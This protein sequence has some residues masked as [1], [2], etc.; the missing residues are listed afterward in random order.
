MNTL[1]LWA[2]CL[3]LTLGAPVYA[4]QDDH[5]ANE[6]AGGHGD[7]EEHGDHDEEGGEEGEGGATE[8]TVAQQRVA[9]IVIEALQPQSL[10]AEIGAPGEVTLNAYLTRK[11]TPRITAQ[12]MQRH[13]RL[14]ERVTIGQPLV[15]L[16]SVQLAEAQGELQVAEREWRRV[17]SLGRSTVSARRYTEAQVAQQQAISRV[18][19]YGMT[20]EQIKALLEGGTAIADGTFQLLA[21][22][23]GTVIRDDFIEGEFVE[24][25]RELFE[26]SDETQIWVEANLTPEEALGVKTG[27]RARVKAGTT[28]FEGR[29]VQAYHVL[30]ETTRTL[31]VRIEVANPDERLH[32]GLF[33]DTR[34]EGA[35][36]IDVFAVPEEAVLRGPDGDWVVLVEEAPGKFESL[37]IEVVRTVAGMAVIEGVPAGTRIVTQGAFFVQSEI[38]KSGFEIH[39]H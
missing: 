37:E 24:P 26:I 11:V 15:T 21:T 19:S 27:A 25:G 3:C 35:A 31:G 34:I 2:L 38:A 30:N 14:G 4:Q 32:P 29:V 10:A 9:G 22:Q 28:W 33:V 18:G 6:T 16:S 8:I 7:E 1:K 39:N 20:A 12:I 5:D 17:E 23:P 13:V 36:L